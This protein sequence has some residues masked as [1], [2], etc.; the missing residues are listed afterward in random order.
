MTFGSETIIQGDCIEQLRALP[1][2]SVDLVFADPPYGPLD[3]DALLGGT[4]AQMAII[5]NDR[6]AS[7][8]AGW[9][10]QKEKRYGTTLV[11]VLV[12]D[13]EDAS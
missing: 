7:A 12:A 3:V 1:D 11:T 2:R 5:E 13:G 10:V 4:K 8:P 9:T 6:F